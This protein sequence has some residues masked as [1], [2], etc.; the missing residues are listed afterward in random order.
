[1]SKTDVVHAG[2]DSHISLGDQRLELGGPLNLR[3]AR[4][5]CRKEA[6]PPLE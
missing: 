5:Q 6:E 3:A 1:M 4:G 2:L